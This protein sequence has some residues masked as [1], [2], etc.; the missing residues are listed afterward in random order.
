MTLG[1]GERNRQATTGMLRNGSTS[2][3]DVTS[4]RAGMLVDRRSVSAARQP[5]A[6]A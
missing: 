2:R 5:E 3:V 4:E 6:G 1:S